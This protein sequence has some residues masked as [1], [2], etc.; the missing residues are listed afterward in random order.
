[1]SNPVPRAHPH[2]PRNDFHMSFLWVRSLESV[3]GTATAMQWVAFGVE[4]VSLFAI[5]RSPW[6][7]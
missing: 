5:Y 4:L 3:V 7:A 1:M 2:P 6:R